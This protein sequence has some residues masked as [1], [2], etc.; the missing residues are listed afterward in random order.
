MCIIDR[1][2][3]FLKINHFAAKMF[4][5][6]REELMKTVIPL[7]L[8]F[9]LAMSF[10]SSYLVKSNEKSKGRL[11]GTRQAVVNVQFPNSTTAS[12]RSDQAS[13]RN[14]TSEKVIMVLETRDK[15]LTIYSRYGVVFTQLGQGRE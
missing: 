8:L 10:P 9:I 15:L 13:D 3:R 6:G 4:A 12:Q 7:P 1:E 14:S 5:S 2:Q 11:L